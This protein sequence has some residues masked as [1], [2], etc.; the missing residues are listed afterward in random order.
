MPY[1]L[2]RD[3]GT[4]P[5]PVPVTP[6]LLAAASPGVSVSTLV[7]ELHDASELEDD[8]VEKA[9]NSLLDFSQ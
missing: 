3:A 6:L 4:V 8:V 2:R 1:V 7:D 5:P 9:R